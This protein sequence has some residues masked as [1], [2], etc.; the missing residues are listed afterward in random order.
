MREIESDKKYNKEFYK[1]IKLLKLKFS[2]KATKFEKNLPF[3][4][5]FTQE[6][7]NKWEI[8]FKFCG[9]L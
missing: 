3:V 8:F 6:H 7:Q 2:E 5:T 4:L 1:I 9:F